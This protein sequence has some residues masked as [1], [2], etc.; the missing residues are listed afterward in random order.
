MEEQGGWQIITQGSNLQP[1]FV[2]DVSQI[3]KKSFAFSLAWNSPT[4]KEDFAG[5]VQVVELTKADKG[6]SFSIKDN[7][8][9]N[10]KSYHFMEPLLD[11]EVIW[12]ADVVGGDTNWKK[13]SLY[14]TRYLKEAKRKKIGRDQYQEE[15]QY[16]FTFRVFERNAVNSFGIMV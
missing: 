4:K 16:R 12:E 9:G 1:A 15:K 10:T 5:I 13:V 3:G 7:Y 14:L 2:K 8:T 6:I 11:G